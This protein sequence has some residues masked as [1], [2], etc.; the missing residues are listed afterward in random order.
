MQEN[1]G[2]LVGEAGFV[3]KSSATYSTQEA[4]AGLEYM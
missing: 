3:S 1:L 2:C 4:L